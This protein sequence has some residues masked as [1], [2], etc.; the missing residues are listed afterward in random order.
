MPKALQV[1][2]SSSHSVRP[3]LRR[4]PRLELMGQIHGFVT[5]LAVPVTVRDISHGGF[6]IEG[7]VEFPVGAVH[8]FKF[9]TAEGVT[10]MLVGEAVHRLRLSGP[11][12]APRFLV[13]F[14]FLRPESP[15]VERSIQL[16]LTSLDEPVGPARH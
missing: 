11:G 13:G 12:M 15:T 9:T 8:D 6:A 7:P 4:A 16:L 10:V 5:S 1:S 14:R 2:T 3:D